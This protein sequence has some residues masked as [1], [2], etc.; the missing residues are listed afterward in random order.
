MTK[1]A[2]IERSVLAATLAVALGAALV[3]PDPVHGHGSSGGDVVTRTARAGDIVVSGG[4]PPTVANDPA[5]D[6]KSVV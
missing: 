6:R 4:G 5:P 2:K 1:G 3:R